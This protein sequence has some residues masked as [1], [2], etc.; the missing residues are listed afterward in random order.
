MRLYWVHVRTR[1]KGSSCCCHYLSS[2]LDNYYVLAS[3]AQ[4]TI[5]K[6][7]N[8]LYRII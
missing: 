8:R 5:N 7:K 6:N 4:Q 2:Y 3:P 1:V